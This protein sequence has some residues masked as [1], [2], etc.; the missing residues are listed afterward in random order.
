M[1]L[2]KKMIVS[3]V[4]I[5]ALLSGVFGFSK[6]TNQIVTCVVTKVENDNKML[7]QSVGYRGFVLDNNVKASV[8]DVISFTYV[9]NKV[10]NIKVIGNEGVT[11]IAEMLYKA[12]VENRNI[13][14][15]NKI[16]IKVTKLI[17]TKFIV[18]K[19]FPH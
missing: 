15:W 2:I 6:S 17:V 5:G 7:C 8:S 10:E 16:K 13:R 12:K 9:N 11:I 14:K 3:L 18:T 4:I 19:L 1:V